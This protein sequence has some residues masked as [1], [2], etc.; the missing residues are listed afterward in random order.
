MHRSKATGQVLVFCATEG[1]TFS[2]VSSSESRYA[3]SCS[4]GG[5][6]DFRRK[7]TPVRKMPR[8]AR[9]PGGATEVPRSPVPCATSGSYQSS[10]GPNGKK[11]LGIQLAGQP[12][13]ASQCHALGANAVTVRSR[14]RPFT[15]PVWFRLVRAPRAALGT[16]EAT[17]SRIR[18][19]NVAISLRRDGASSRLSE[20]ATIRAASRCCFATTVGRSLQLRS[21]LWSPRNWT[22]SPRS[23]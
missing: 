19:T 18:S 5:W 1:V 3:P 16:C 14:K 9:A 23:S 17:T 7:V 15:G 13:A 11:F 2:K 10:L 21:S 4:H 8:L 12:L 20:T 6:C 22:R